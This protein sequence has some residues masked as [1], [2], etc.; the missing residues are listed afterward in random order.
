M[1]TLD[2][3]VT[4]FIVIITHMIEWIIHRTSN[5]RIASSD[6]GSNPVRGKPLLLDQET[7]HH[8]SVLVDPGTDSRC[9]NSF[10]HNQTK[11]NSV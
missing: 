4:L 7:L 9:A 1:F 8:C 3:S 6:M 10:L 5:L 2:F 11:I